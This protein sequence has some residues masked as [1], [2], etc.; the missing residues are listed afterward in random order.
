[1][2][3]NVSNGLE[4]K[5]YCTSAVGMEGWK[6]RYQASERESCAAAAQ[7]VHGYYTTY[8]L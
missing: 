8:G 5:S 2:E 7:V 3:L 1:M 6:L 4:L